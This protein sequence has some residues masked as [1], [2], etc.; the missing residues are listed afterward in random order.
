MYPRDKGQLSPYA[1]E[2]YIPPPSPSRG[3]YGS[4]RGR[5]GG[6][7]MMYHTGQQAG[8]YRDPEPQGIFKIFSASSTLFSILLMFLKNDGC[9]HFVKYFRICFEISLFFYTG[10][11]GERSRLMCTSSSGTVYGEPAKSMPVPGSYPPYS[12]SDNVA[13]PQYPYNPNRFSI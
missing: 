12:Q 7:N 8:G 3:S 2:E 1:D 4:L 6:G 13:E 9:F 5:R 10:Y 11:G